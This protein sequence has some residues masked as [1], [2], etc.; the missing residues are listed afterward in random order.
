MPH[1][2]VYLE[3]F[4]NYQILVHGNFLDRK[5]VKN[6]NPVVPQI[7]LV[8]QCSRVKS[9]FASDVQWSGRTAAVNKCNKCELFFFFSLT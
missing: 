2:G 6:F 3:K 4:K 8:D 5:G 9:T 1:P 7:K